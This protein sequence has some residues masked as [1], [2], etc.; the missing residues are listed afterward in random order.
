M[1]IILF[2]YIFHDSLVDNRVD[3]ITCFMTLH[4]VPQ[5]NPILI[6][7]ARILRPGGYLILREHDCKNERSLTAKYLNFVHAFMMIARV[8]E[9]A[10]APIKHLNQNQH[11]SDGD[12]DSD[13]SNWNKQ[14]LEIIKFTNS[15]QYRTRGEWHKELE[16]VHFH[17][18]ATLDYDLNESSNPQEVFYAVYQLDAK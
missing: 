4:H 10:D 9:F 3:L 15:I 16:R 18:I 5:I 2:F 1:V 12:L 11:P 13:T 8:G 14:K 7:L 17:L 6:E